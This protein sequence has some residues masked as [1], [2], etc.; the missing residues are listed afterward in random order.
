[1][2]ASCLG[3]QE[4]KLM[5]SEIVSIAEVNARVSRHNSPEDREHDELV[6]SLRREIRRVVER[7]KY[8]PINAEAHGCEEDAA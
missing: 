4:R 1:V 3:I 2:A 6:A 7:P 5:G 8:R